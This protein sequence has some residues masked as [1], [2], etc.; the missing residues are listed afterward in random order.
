MAD[1]SLFDRVL[2]K[3]FGKDG[4]RED[5]DAQLI[6]ELTDAIV[7]TVEPRVRAH[8][9]YRRELEGSVRTTLAW[10]RNIARMPL[11]PVLLER[12]RWGDDPRLNS[13]FG[14]PDAI[15]EFLGHSRELRAFFDDPAN[16]G[17]Q[18]AFALMGMRKEEKTVFGPRYEDGLLKQDV[19]QTAVNF[20]GHRLAAPAGTAAQARLEV[21]RRVVLRL[22]QVTLTRIIEIDRKGLNLEQ[23]K[24]WLST[25]LRML[26]LA[27]D[28]MH[29]LVDDPTTIE[30]QIDEV[31]HQLNESVK[32]FIEVKST[33]ATLDGYIDVIREE[34]SH[35]E[36]HVVLTRSKLTVTRMN[37]KADQDTEEPHHTLTLAEL[38]V[39]DRLEAVIAPVRIPRSELPPK[40]DLLAKAER[41]L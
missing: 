14:A 30:Q 28:G 5:A 23:Q 24:A 22:A 2:S 8:R 40:E 17:V 25:R 34:F 26:K 1:E 11:E 10:L 13:F 31:E 18:E 7:D 33:L 16:A 6:A 9:H 15:T 4:E 32:G 41:F 29:S 27:R 39:G 35:P 20:T 38:R 12:A 37:I 3:L 36:Q 21:G 19:A